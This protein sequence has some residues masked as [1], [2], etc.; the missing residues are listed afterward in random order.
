[1][2]IQQYTNGNMGAAGAACLRALNIDAAADCR[3]VAAD[4]LRERGQTDFAIAILESPLDPNTEPYHRVLKIEKLAELEAYDAV[5]RQLA[6]LDEESLHD[7]LRVQLSTS[8]ATAGLRDEA[9]AMLKGVSGEYWDKAQLLSAQF[10][11]AMSLGDFD[12]AHDY[13]YELQALD[14]WNDPLLRQR[15]EL[16]GADLS[17]G[18]RWIDLR[19][20]AALLGAFGAI[21]LLALIVPVS[22]HY[23][24][25][26]R[27]TKGLAAGLAESTWTLRH[28]AYAILVV[29]LFSVL[30]LYI[31]EYDLFFASYFGEYW[32][33]PDWRGADL[34]KILLMNTIALTVLLSPLVLLKGRWRQ[35]GPGNWSIL[36]CIGVGIGLAIV[37]RLL[38]AI[39]IALSP[40]FDVFGETMLTPEAIRRLYVAYGL[41]TALVVTAVLVPL[42]EEVLFRGMALQGFS[43]HVTYTAANLLQSV[44]FAGLHESLLLFPFFVAFGFAVG[45]TVRKA[46]GLLPAIVAHALFN[47]IAVVGMVAI[48]SQ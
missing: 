21:I 9:L 46:G 8:L 18:W 37:M 11:V 5:A 41:V 4:H 44:I 2:E 1:M 31:F 14:Y 29:L 23:R 36:K 32:E 22:V 42:V 20:F 35:L 13:Y 19:G 17:L 3:L 15:F 39:P 25:L 34:A 48:V 16:A 28:A 38:F 27:R 43:R 33:E 30:L 6:Q 47:A 26:I 10:D 24:G 45:L 12:A 40:E 7:H